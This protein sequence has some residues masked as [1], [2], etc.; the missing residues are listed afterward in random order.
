MSPSNNVLK[1]AIWRSNFH[2]VLPRILCEGSYN[3]TLFFWLVLWFFRF[4]Q[5]SVWKFS[6]FR[7]T[8]LQLVFQWLIYNKSE[9]RLPTIIRVESY[10]LILLTFKKTCFENSPQEKSNYYCC[11]RQALRLNSRTIPAT[12]SIK[13][14][15][16]INLAGS[17]S[18]LW[19][20]VAGTL[21]TVIYANYAKIH[22]H[23]WKVK[24]ENKQFLHKIVTSSLSKKLL[25]VLHKTLF[26]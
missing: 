6:I 4:N 24:F 13:K 21:I 20:S 22:L 16:T 26:P 12:G 14:L 19:Y 5:P 15:H 7:L 8:K 1:P 3:K 2:G 18:E 17:V 25:R 9:S 10:S 11:K 23:M